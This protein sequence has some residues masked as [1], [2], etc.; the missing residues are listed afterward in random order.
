M[1]EP[2]PLAYFLQLKV[3]FNLVPRVEFFK[4]PEST[5]KSP[6][7][8]GAVQGAN[9]TSTRPV[10]KADLLFWTL[11]ASYIDRVA[12]LVSGDAQRMAVLHVGGRV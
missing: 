6:V 1:A 3:I 9:A 10:Y 8:K 5:P 2:S 11:L 7:T 12:A 4:Q